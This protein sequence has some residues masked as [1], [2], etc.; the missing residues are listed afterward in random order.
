MSDG[1]PN[2]KDRPRR[3]R[4]IVRMIVWMLLSFYLPFFEE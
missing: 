3:I 2:L 4:M 1:N